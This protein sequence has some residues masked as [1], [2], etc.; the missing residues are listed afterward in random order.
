[1]TRL[2][3]IAALLPCLAGAA[4]SPPTAAEKALV[5]TEI[6]KLLKDPSSAQYRWPERRHDT[7]YCGWV[8]AKNSFGGYEGYRPFII[9]IIR[10][11]KLSPMVA[12]GHLIDL[13]Q[14]ELFARMCERAGLDLSVPALEFPAE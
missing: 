11:D 13:E 8:N 14:D 12:A 9:N 2:L 4:P 1:M 10:V 6:G 3:A 7:T 5:R